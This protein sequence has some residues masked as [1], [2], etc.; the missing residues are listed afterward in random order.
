MAGNKRKHQRVPTLNLLSY[1]CIDEKGN[2]SEQGM[3]KAVDISQGG[4][5]IETHVPIVSHYILLAAIGIDDQ[6][7]KVK[8]EV[9]HCTADNSG[10]YYTGVRF[11]ETS[12][13]IRQIVVNM[14]KVNNLQ[15]SSLQNGKNN[16]HLNDNSNSP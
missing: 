3:G 6:L 10:K 8:G 4:M 9:M 16:Q 15:K 11:I 13:K 12:E 14:I 2:K 1:V 5:R 7:I